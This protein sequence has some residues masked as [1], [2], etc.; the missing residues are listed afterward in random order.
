MLAQITVLRSTTTAVT[1]SAKICNSGQTVTYASS[2]AYEASVA[3]S[4]VTLTMVS[5]IVL[6]VST[7]IN[8]MAT[9]NQTATIKAALLTNAAGNTATQLTAIKIA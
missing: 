3:N 1:Y 6:G 7:T 2:G 4:I 9:A 8:V 5:R